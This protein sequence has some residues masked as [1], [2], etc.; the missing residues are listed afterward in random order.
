LWRNK[1]INL[2][3]TRTQLRGVLTNGGC[4]SP[5]ETS[6]I[7]L[8]HTLNRPKSWI[9][10]HDEYSLNQQ[11]NHTL[12]T[13]LAQL[14][15]GVPLPYVLGRWD[16]YGHTFHITPDVLIPRPE[17]EL[18]VEHAL[19]HAGAF[20]RPLIVDVGTG[21][22]AIAITLAEELPG[23]TI[24][25]VDLSMAALRVAQANAQ[26]LCPSRVSFF[27]ADLLTP[28]STQFDLICAN[29]PY[30]PSQELDRLPVSHWEPHNALDGGDSGLDVINSLLTQAQTRLSPTG[31]ILLEIHAT[32]GAETMAAVQAAYPH[33]HYQLMRDLAGLDRIVVIQQ[34]R[35]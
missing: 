17:T 3:K 1:P 12:Q 10:S 18:L 25:G 8:Q 26:R 15:Q 22:G 29:L 27:Q 2:Q 7:L 33:A 34:N 9:L 23:A 16:F 24:L 13:S 30:I 14:L 31:V 32:L 35:S 19:Q 21:S 6:L 20:H 4:E 11:E 28:F 5:G